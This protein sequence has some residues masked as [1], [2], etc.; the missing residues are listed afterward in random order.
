[1][2]LPIIEE[3]LYGQI[4]LETSAWSSTFTWVDRTADL[5]QGI[6]YAQG[7]RVGLPGYSS[8]DVGTLNATF[9][10]LATAPL[11]GDL[12]RLR[13]T[14]TTEYAFIGY[15][16]DVS[17]QVVF[18]N[19]VSLNT[20]VVLTNINCLD[21]VGYVSQFDAIGV[22]GLAATTFAKQTTYPYQSRARA[23]NN[24]IDPT[25]ATQLIAFDATSAN[26]VFG[27]TDDVGTFSDHLDLAAFTQ[28]L[29]WHGNNVLPTNKTTGRTGLITIRPLTTAPSS[30]KTFTD[31]AGTAGQLHYTEID[32]QSS[33]Q[34]VAN[35]IVIDNHVVREN[36]YLVSKLG[37]ANESNFKIIN[38]QNV[39]AYSVDHVYA[40]S[41]ATSVTTYGNRTSTFRTNS[42]SSSG[43]I[44]FVGNPSF[45]YSEQ[46]WEGS[47][48]KVVRR[49]PAENSTPFA[50]DSGTWAL[51][52]RLASTST[53]PEMRYAGTEIDG[54]PVDDNVSFG[55]KISGARGA[56][57]RADVRGRAFIR[58]YDE[59]DSVLSTVF[60]SQVTFGSTPYVWQ[61]M[62]LTGIAPSNAVR[63]VVGIEWN[64][65]G[66]GTFSAGDQFW[67]DSALFRFATTT[68]SLSYFDGD[69]PTSATYVHTWTGERGLSP[70]AQFLNELDTLATTYLTRYSTTS[71]RITRI[72][73]NAQEDLTAV[74]AL[75]VG[76]TT[77]I[78]YDGTTTT[79]RI[80]GV[81]GN[82][83]P[84]RY[85]IDYYL[86]KV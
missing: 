65:S 10:N 42:L 6:N 62:S 27:D 38:N 48:Q 3:P 66:G 23:L 7:G 57:N 30:G 78:T 61:T 29:Y 25:N 52:M 49:Q 37:G 5:V 74:S 22:G 11:V 39:A 41:D 16:Q 31:V 54:M 60:S 45:E 84:D 15:V 20:P 67:A 55:F 80:V 50:A 68:A 76:S 73:W 69:T 79:H 33:S 35:T 32:L 75:A 81:D 77:Q 56:P 12:V 26:S 85:M 17:Q 43:E 1:M 83:S 44:N 63:A 53:S 34:N 40:D 21:W 59:N 71:N 58:W 4:T 46:G 36:N 64:R 14:G 28:N 86:E 8:V 2:A 82:V 47:L 18:D 24:I 72:R 19:S 51:R 9:K 70:S 13:R